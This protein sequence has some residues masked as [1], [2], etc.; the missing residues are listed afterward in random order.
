MTR[1][2][3]VK[4]A[5]G[6]DKD[7]FYLVLRL[8]GDYAYIADGKVR[9]LERP[10]KKRIKHLRPTA[11]VMNMDLF[12]GNRSLLKALRAYNGGDSL[13]EGGYKLV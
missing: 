3:V 13:S 2:S 5:A 12:V 8:E 10:K 9:P 1:G 6:R 7:R 4:S 11:D